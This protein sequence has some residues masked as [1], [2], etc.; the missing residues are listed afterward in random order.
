MGINGP[1]KLV[2][3]YGNDLQS[4]TMFLSGGAISPTGTS[5]VYLL[6]ARNY[7]DLVD[8]NNALVQAIPISGSS[9]IPGYDTGGAAIGASMVEFCQ[10]RIRD[11]ISGSVVSQN[12]ESGTITGTGDWTIGYYV[13]IVGDDD[14][15]S[16]AYT[17][18]AWPTFTSG[19]TNNSALISWQ[20]NPGVTAY[21]IYAYTNEYGDYMPFIAEVPSGTTSYHDTSGTY[22]IYRRYNY[23][24]DAKNCISRGDI[25]VPVSWE[26]DPYPWQPV[27]ATLVT[28]SIQAG[29]NY[30]PIGYVRINPSNYFNTLPASGSFVMP[31]G[32]AS[33]EKNPIAFFISV[34]DYTP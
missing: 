8:F 23:G 27:S 29:G 16:W 6:Y 25:A 18:D 28:A 33:P 26:P 5:D 14:S 20:D 31:S 10:M 2:D 13:A 9:G 1:A 11:A 19:S 7:N 34:S 21:R 30:G 4:L 3:R 22:Q 15:E 32:S 12:L 17:S 24:A